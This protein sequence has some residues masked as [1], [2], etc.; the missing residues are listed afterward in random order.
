MVFFFEAGRTSTHA[1]TKRYN[2]FDMADSYIVPDLD[3]GDKEPVVKK[4]IA[5]R[6]QNEKK[7]VVTDAPKKRAVYR[8]A[9]VTSAIPKEKATKEEKPVTV[10]DNTMGLS[11]EQQAVLEEVKKG[12]SVVIDSV[13]GSGKT[14]T[15]QAICDYFS[16]LKILYLTYNKLLKLDAQKKITNRNVTVQNYHGFVYRY[17]INHPI[18][19]LT[20]VGG[21]RGC[22]EKFLKTE[23]T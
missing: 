15:L 23:R 11:D 1:P 10:I 2:D 6:L 16:S 22:K 9:S 20:L 8:G 19:P 12:N 13:I 4:E 3:Y 21:Y 18:S 14:R 7:R 17:L 5:E